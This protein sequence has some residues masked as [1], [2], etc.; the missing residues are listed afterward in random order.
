MIRYT[1][2]LMMMSDNE[3]RCNLNKNNRPPDQTNIATYIYTYTYTLKHINTYIE[4]YRQTDG[5]TERQSG[6]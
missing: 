3:E 6:R 4:T 5:H 2:L 1:G